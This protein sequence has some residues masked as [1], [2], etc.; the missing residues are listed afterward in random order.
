MTVSHT[1]VWVGT[2]SV[3]VVRAEVGETGTG[4]DAD[5]VVDGEHA[6]STMAKATANRLA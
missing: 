4:Y 2:D 5:R 1:G 6:V 3:A